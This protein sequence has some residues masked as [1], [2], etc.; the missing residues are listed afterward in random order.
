MGRS[1]T[2]LIRLVVATLAAGSSLIVALAVYYWAMTERF[3]LNVP[4]QKLLLIHGVAVIYCAVGSL[5]LLALLSVFGRFRPLSRWTAATIGGL[6]FWLAPSALLLHLGPGLLAL[7]AGMVAG[8]VLFGTRSDAPAGGL[9][10]KIALACGLL[11]W[12]GLLLMPAREA[13]KENKLAR[14]PATKSLL[15][16][17][18]MGGAAFG[19]ELWLFNQDGKAV[20]FRLADWRPTLRS[21]S[22]VAALGSA[23]KSMVALIAPAFDWR[24][25]HQPAGRFRLA[26]YSQGGWAYGGWQDYSAGE[27]PLALAVL[28]DRSIIL[29]PKKLYSVQSDTGSV[30]VLPLSQA[31]KSGGEF[32]TAV[33]GDGSMYV[34]INAGEF[35]GGLL[36]V[37][38]STGEVTNV[39]KRQDK[40]LC[41]GP[42]NSACD[43]VTG[44][45]PDLNR[46][47]CVF[48]SV[49]L[50]HWEWHGRVLR[51][52]GDRVETVFEAK[53]LPVG[54]RIRRAFSSRARSFPPQT[55]P[56]FALAPAKDGFWAVTPRALYK[57]RQGTVDR[58][59]FPSLDPVHGLAVSKAVPGLVVTTTDAN[60]AASLSGVTPLVFAT[61]Q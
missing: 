16:E 12:L 15:G 35:G 45:V 17:R 59:A 24:A 31:I 14:Q 25:D 8:A 47:G 48:A 52:C 13:W 26:S 58:T 30:A 36:R 11:V 42:L 4:W 1:R 34:G 38:L 10:G 49:G 53:V 56:V 21:S 29:G 39:E 6:L 57:W 7:P 3:S 50:S 27:R 33:T 28:S 23:G 37:R 51:I 55:E 44:L 19:S 43:P 20:S 60:A 9:P 41:S 2:L 32:V 18:V 5:L 61:D 46:S 22:G 40:E 54:E